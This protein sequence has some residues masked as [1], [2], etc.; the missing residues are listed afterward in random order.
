MYVCIYWVWFNLKKKTIELISSLIL[1]VA[2]NQNQR[3]HIST[4]KGGSQKLV[5][6]FTYLGSSGSSTEND[7]NKPLAKSWS[8]IDKL[9][10]RWKSD[11]SDKIKRK[12]FQ[13][14]IVSILQ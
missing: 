10:A 7:I 13:V 9:S 12:F 6:T 4:L 11:L 2:Y 5:G 3:G 14:A 8:A 1:I